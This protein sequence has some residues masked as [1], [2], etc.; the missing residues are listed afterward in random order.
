MCQASFLEE[1]GAERNK[2]ADQNDGGRWVVV[3][4]ELALFGVGKVRHRMVVVGRSF[5]QS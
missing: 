5:L 2:E 3:G 4:F 1:V